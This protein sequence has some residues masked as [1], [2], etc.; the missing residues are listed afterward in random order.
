MESE[1]DRSDGVSFAGDTAREISSNWY[2]LPDAILLHIFQYL[3]AKEL[4]DVGLTCRSW[5]RVSYDE[6]L[7]KDLFYHNF[8]IDPSVKIVPGMCNIL[9]VE[10]LFYLHQLVHLFYNS[11]VCILHMIFEFLYIVE[12]NLFPVSRMK[13]IDGVYMIFPLIFSYYKY[14]GLL[15]QVTAYFPDFLS[16][17]GNYSY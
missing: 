14:Q 17:R 4:L 2:Y 6:L 10:V 11:S 8:K 5:L 16:F 13:L 1:E 9:L 12:H 7:W 15:C 3:S